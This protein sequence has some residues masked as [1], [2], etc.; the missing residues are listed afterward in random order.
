MIPQSNVVFFS[1]DTVDSGSNPVYYGNNNAEII[2]VEIS[3]SFTS[4]A[5]HFEGQVDL[6]NED[7]TPIAGV[8]L[9]DYS[10]T[11]NPTG[12]GVWEVPIE[13]LQR[14]RV[15]VES[16]SGGEAKVF[17]RVIKTGV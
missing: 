10:I 5:F 3:G 11:A 14:F 7:W 8:D 16:V 1:G 12:A 15:R 17:G 13:G 2:S 9:S 6:A 4:G